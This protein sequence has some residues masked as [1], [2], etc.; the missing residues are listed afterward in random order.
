MRPVESPGGSVP[1]IFHGKPKAMNTQLQGQLTTPQGYDDEISLV[2]LAGMLVKRWKLMAAVFVAVI[3][4]ALVYALITPHSYRYVT[5]YQVAQQAVSSDS[6][7]VSPLETPE[8]VVAK[9]KSLYLGPVTRELIAD[10]KRETMPFAINVSSV[11]DTYLV[12]LAS[13]TTADNSALVEQAHTMVV[14]RAKQSQQK[15][16]EQRRR[17]LEQQLSSAESA[18][19][20]VKNSTSDNAGELIATY[21]SRASSIQT[22]ISQLEEGQINQTAVKSLHS[23]GTSRTLIMALAVLLGGMLAAMAVF[24]AAFT[25]SVRQSLKSEGCE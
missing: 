11:E 18:L 22:R 3:A 20:S 16:L 6:A 12:K 4:A 14:N 24:V 9:I 19:E 1:E 2:E 15:L 17:S 10:S 7:G 13:E 23:V 5:I 25:S 21:S 8:A